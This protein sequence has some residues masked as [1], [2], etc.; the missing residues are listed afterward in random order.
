MEESL[1]REID[2]Q[3]EQARAGSL[4]F[5]ADD[6]IGLTLRQSDPFNAMMEN[7]AF[8]FYFFEHQYRKNA[9]G[10]F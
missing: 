3:R 2:H 10:P 4:I 1:K 7:N 6:S 8:I 5:Q 9:L